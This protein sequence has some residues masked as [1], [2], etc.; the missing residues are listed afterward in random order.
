MVLSVAASEIPDARRFAA[1]GGL[2][3]SPRR[4]HEP[5]AAMP[6]NGACR[7]GIL[8]V[9]RM[10]ETRRAVLGR[11]RIARRTRRGAAR[12]SEKKQS[13]PSK[14]RSLEDTPDPFGKV[15]S[16]ALRG[17][18]HRFELDAGDANAQP[19]VFRRSSPGF[20]LCL[21]RI[22]KCGITWRYGQT[23]QATALPVFL[24]GFDQIAA[25]VAEIRALFSEDLLVAVHLPP[26]TLLGREPKSRVYYG[27]VNPPTQESLLR[28]LFSAPPGTILALYPAPRS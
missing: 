16:F 18:I 11:S 9:A 12:K 2:D 14:H 3:K 5:R 24:S 4:A 21:H 22:Y 20:S 6:P 15:L 7:V 8:Q 1:I 25:R 19:R 10:S 23:M 27:R 26:P 17:A 13:R 28:T